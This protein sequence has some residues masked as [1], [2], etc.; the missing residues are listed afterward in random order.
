MKRLTTIIL[1]VV[2]LFSLVSCNFTPDE[3]ITE[4]TQNQS[5]PESPSD[6]TPPVS[7]TESKAPESTN[8]KNTT[9][10]SKLE[11]STPI[12]STLD[13]TETQDEY[14]ESTGEF[15]Y[16]SK[17]PLFDPYGEKF[18]SFEEMCTVHL[19]MK[20]SEVISKIGKA[21]DSIPTSSILILIWETEKN[22]YTCMVDFWWACDIYT[23]DDLM[24]YCVVHEVIIKDR[25][26]NIVVK[27]TK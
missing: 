3:P 8:E 25:A 20:L 17:D 24:E 7:N 5:A 22:D 18:P 1:S 13:S 19:G 2:L 26:G 15:T 27:E 4:P 21:H 11:E 14:D 12:E 10:E 9:T 16:F 6:E 23:I